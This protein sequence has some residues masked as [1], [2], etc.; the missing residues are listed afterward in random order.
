MP[1]ELVLFEKGLK[2]VSAKNNMH[3]LLAQK[4]TNGLHNKL[5]ACDRLALFERQER[6]N[7]ISGVLHHS[8][9]SSA[10]GVQNRYHNGAGGIFGSVFDKV[11]NGLVLVTMD[12]GVVVRRVV[13]ICQQTGNGPLLVP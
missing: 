4:W 6:C 12:H 7:G 11:Q 9:W 8:C 5:T 3:Y 2:V 10:L 13:P 1:N